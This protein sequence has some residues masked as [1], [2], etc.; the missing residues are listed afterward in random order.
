MYHVA[1]YTFFYPLITLHDAISFHQSPTTTRAV[2]YV[3]SISTYYEINATEWRNGQ[4]RETSFTNYKYNTVQANLAT[5]NFLLLCGC[6]NISCCLC[7]F[8][9][10]TTNYLYL[11][12]IKSIASQYCSCSRFNITEIVIVVKYSTII[13]PNIHMFIVVFLWHC[14]KREGVLDLMILV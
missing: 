8:S 1:I 2:S 9:G 6:F 4:F 3:R 11:S 5:V 10:F 13:V 14:L 12:W 7:C